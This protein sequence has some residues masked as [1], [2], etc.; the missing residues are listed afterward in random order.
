[1]NSMRSSLRSLLQARVQMPFSFPLCF[2]AHGFFRIDIISS[3]YNSVQVLQFILGGFIFFL[4]F[5]YFL[6]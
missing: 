6:D 4:I 1:M 3:E 5:Y 2:S